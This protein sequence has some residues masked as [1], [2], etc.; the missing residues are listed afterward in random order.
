MDWDTVLTI[1]GATFFS[2][3]S[4]GAIIAACVKFA[5]NHISEK[6]VRKYDA[7]LS[8][9][10]E[11]YKHELEIETEKYKQRA[12][13]LTFVTQKQFDTEFLAYQVIFDNLF[14]FSAHTAK[15]YPTFDSVPADEEERKE[16]YTKRY[17]DYRESFNRFSEALEKNAPFVPKKH[18]E[19]FDG[20]R[21][22]A[23]E[24]GC[25]YPDVRICG[26]PIYAE[27]YKEIAKENYQRTREFKNEILNAQD[28]IRDY[29]ATLKIEKNS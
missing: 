21:Q 25:M 18:Y 11:S 1:I 24:L 29:L 3:G 6:M 28:T 27:D 16:V 20:L 23:H 8:K 10:L 12:E 4:A 9:D 19:L 15:L 7:K 17:L 13:R 22:R 2:V 5:A 26:D 14:S